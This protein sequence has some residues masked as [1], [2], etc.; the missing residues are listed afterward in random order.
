MVYKNH[1]HSLTFHES[2]GHSYALLLSQAD[3][4]KYGTRMGISVYRVTDFAPPGVHDHPEFF[5]VLEGHG[6]MRVDDEEFSI[7]P[8]SF[9]LV[10]P[11]AHHTL[12]RNERSLPVK[13][14]WTHL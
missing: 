9:V 12:R 4:A 10:P 3:E 7:S 13:V 2:P 14:L 11:G 1:E 8:G 5:Y 6:S